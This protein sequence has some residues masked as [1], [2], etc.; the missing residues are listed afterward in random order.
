MRWL[1]NTADPSTRDWL[2]SVIPDPDQTAAEAVREFREWLKDKVIGDPKAS[3]ALS[4]E[5][6]KK[7]GMVGVYLP[8]Q[9]ELG[10]SNDRAI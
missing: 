5:Q 6:L 1:T 8:A 10:V 4:V 7:Q 9:L 3:E 2:T